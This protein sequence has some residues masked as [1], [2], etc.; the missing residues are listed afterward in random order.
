[1][2]RRLRWT[3]ENPDFSAFE[4]PEPFAGPPCLELQDASAC[5]GLKA[6][7]APPV[8]KLKGDEGQGM[9][10]REGLVVKSSFHV[11]FSKNLRCLCHLVAPLSEHE[12]LSKS[13]QV[14]TV[15]LIQKVT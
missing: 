7:T 2:K 10:A 3:E 13:P 11:C 5:K 14:M 12:N 1:M 4:K 8:K 6:E 9:D 15:H